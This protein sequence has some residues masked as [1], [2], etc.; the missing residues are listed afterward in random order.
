M[1]EHCKPY[2]EGGEEFVT[3]L[4]T[5]NSHQNSPDVCID[6]RLIVSVMFPPVVAGPI[7]YCPMCG[8]KLG[9]DAL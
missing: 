6:E 3:P 9:G 7:N 4:P 1:C 2:I 5:P 8:R